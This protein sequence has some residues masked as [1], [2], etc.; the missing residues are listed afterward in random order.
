MTEILDQTD[1]TE[2]AERLVLAAKRAG[3]TASDA[4]CVRGI[5]LSVEVRM[6]K[7]E[8]TRRAE[9]DDFTLRVFVGETLGDHLG[10][11][12]LRP[13]SRSLSG[14]WPWPR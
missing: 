6:G 2:R 1:L 8:E 4:V 5:A 11:R 13:R 10:Q 12:L 3:A 9:G 14:P 7:V